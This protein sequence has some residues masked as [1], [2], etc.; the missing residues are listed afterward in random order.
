MENRMQIINFIVRAYKSQSCQKKRIIDRG[1]ASAACMFS[2]GLAGVHLS[3]LA[4]SS[5]CGTNGSTSI[6][7]ESIVGLRNFDNNEYGTGLQHYQD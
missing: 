5:S 4:K 1:K 3:A 2:E 6:R 7:Q